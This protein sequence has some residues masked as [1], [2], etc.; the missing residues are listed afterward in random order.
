[1]TARLKDS[2]RQVNV[3][4]DVAHLIRTA[5]LLVAQS[6]RDHVD[7][8]TLRHDPAFQS[9]VS[10]ASGLTTLNVP[11]LVAQPTLSRLTAL[12][13]GPGNLKILRETVLELAGREIRIGLMGKR[14]RSITIDVDSAPIEV[15]SRRRKAK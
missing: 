12:M 10:S 3:A 13:P 8:D 9:A 4:R 5:V 1:M 7:N 2:R 15:H 14:I 11:G 6:W